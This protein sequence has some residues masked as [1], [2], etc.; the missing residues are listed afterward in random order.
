[1]SMY[2]TGTV[3]AAA[4]ATTITGSGTK[5]ADQRNGIGPQ[6]TIAIYGAG[7]VDLYAIAR[8]DSDTQLTV[9][10][11]VSKAFSG[12]R[13]RRDGGRNPERCS[14]GQTCSRHSSATISRQMDGWQ[15]IMTGDGSVTVTAPDGREVTISSFKKL[16]DDMAGKAGSG[17]N[18]DITGLNALGYSKINPTRVG[19]LYGTNATTNTKNWFAFSNLIEPNPKSETGSGD[20]GATGVGAFFIGGGGDIYYQYEGNTLFRL[21]IDGALN[22]TSGRIYSMGSYNGTTTA[23]AN[24][25][26]TTQGAFARSTSSAK[27]KTQVET[28]KNSYADK[29]QELRPVWYRSTCENDNPDWGWYGFIA[30]EVGEILPQMV[31]WREPNDGESPTNS[32]GMIAEGVMYE[33]FTPLLLN[34]LMRLKKE[35]DTLKEKLRT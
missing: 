3:S 12:S 1:M 26:I 28:L 17:E 20:L 10:R 6:C 2:E 31:H 24:V 14:T 33:R 7:T 21:G 27:Y 13:L 8:V 35:V 11:P 30:E 22:T 25:Y 29:M 18:N 4:D 32:N 19:H 34:E 15:E 16:T 9:T 23:G 5:W